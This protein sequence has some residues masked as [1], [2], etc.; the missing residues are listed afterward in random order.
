MKDCWKAVLRRPCWGGRLAP[1][2]RAQ[3]LPPSAA[4]GQCCTRHARA[5]SSTMSFWTS[6]GGAHRIPESLRHLVSLR[7]PLAR[8]GKAGRL[9]AVTWP[10]GPATLPSPAQVC[11]AVNGD[12]NGGVVWRV[13]A[14]SKAAGDT[15]LAFSSRR[16]AS[17]IHGPFYLGQRSSGVKAG[18]WRGWRG[19]HHPCCGSGE[20]GSSWLEHP[21]PSQGQGGGGVGWLVSS[22]PVFFFPPLGHHKQA[23][24]W[25]RP[26]DCH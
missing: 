23:V 18:D 13:P 25:L 4:L 2:A 9:G 11:T 12:R 6:A 5:S 21:P 15:H 17:I 7:T 16:E 24:A 19:A 8:K 22:L 10:P 14:G 20:S 26:E 3:A 1:A